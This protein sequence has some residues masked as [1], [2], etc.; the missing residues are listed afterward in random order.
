[1]LHI[2][3]YWVQ[4]AAPIFGEQAVFV[5]MPMALAGFLTRSVYGACFADYT[6]FNSFLILETASMASFA[7]RS[8][9]I[10]S[11]YS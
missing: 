4:K 2:C 9:P 7:Y 10:L 6:T 8:A 11:A 3:K 5:K 1:M